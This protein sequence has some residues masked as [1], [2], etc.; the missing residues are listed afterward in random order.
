MSVWA[1]RESR[2][3]VCGGCGAVSCF[4]AAAQRDPLQKARAGAEPPSPRHVTVRR[5][6][7]N[8]H[9][10]VSIATQVGGEDAAW[11][12]IFGENRKIFEMF[13]VYSSFFFP[14]WRLVMQKRI[15]D[16]AVNGF[17]VIQRRN[18]RYPSYRF[19]WKLTQIFIKGFPNR[20]KPY[21]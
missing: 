21:R 20:M 12:C 17:W 10:R 11:L 5:L 7:G 2:W 14:V 8:A 16:F 9:A 15:G 3:A 6:M 13:N 19:D 4:T 1:K 18:G